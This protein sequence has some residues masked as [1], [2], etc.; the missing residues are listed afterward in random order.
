MLRQPVPAD[1]LWISVPKQWERDG[2]K[3]QMSVKP[4]IPNVVSVSYDRGWL[5]PPGHSTNP[6]GKVVT[7]KDSQ[8]IEKGGRGFV[9]A[10]D[11]VVRSNCEDVPAI[12]EGLHGHRPGDGLLGC[13]FLPIQHHQGK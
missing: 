9:P 7:V 8:W 4:E 3:A 10:V 11:K 6:T 1:S 2:F 5:Q 13:T 12:Q